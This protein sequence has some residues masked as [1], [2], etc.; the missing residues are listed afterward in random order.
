MDFF[1]S[2]AGSLSV[3]AGKGKDGEGV[4]LAACRSIIFIQEGME[5]RGRDRW[6]SFN[7]AKK[8]IAQVFGFIFFKKI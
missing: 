3:T 1:F 4:R 8:K 2:A 7:F 6:T 5:R